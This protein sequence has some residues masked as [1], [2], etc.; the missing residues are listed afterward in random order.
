MAIME[1]IEN[2]STFD[3]APQRL[4]RREPAIDVLTASECGID[5]LTDP[6]LQGIAVR[7][8]AYRVIARSEIHAGSF[9]SVRGPAW[10][11][12]DCARLVIY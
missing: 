9:R 10:T 3:C 7:E 11:A 5:D 6:E 2:W 4:L 12:I 8:R 1:V